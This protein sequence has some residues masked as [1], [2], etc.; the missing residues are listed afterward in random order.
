MKF[1]LQEPVKSK[2]ST[3]NGL[4][5]IL[6]FHRIN[7]LCSVVLFNYIYICYKNEFMMHTEKKMFVV[8]VSY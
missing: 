1:R 8:Q 2:E 7:H 6:R 5:Q 3:K 4:L